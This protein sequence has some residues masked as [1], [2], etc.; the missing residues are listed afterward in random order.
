MQHDVLS[1]SRS[2]TIAAALNEDGRGGNVIAA[3][4]RGAP[5]RRRDDVFVCWTMALC[6]PMRLWRPMSW[7]RFTICLITFPVRNLST[8]DVMG[9]F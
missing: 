4:G 7:N 5:G 1:T 9:G 3:R 6:T 2:F 8:S